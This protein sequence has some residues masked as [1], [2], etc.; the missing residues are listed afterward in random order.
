M[1]LCKYNQ[2]QNQAQF[3]QYRRFQA[4]KEERSSVNKLQNKTL[5]R[6]RRRG[7]TV[8]IFAA[9][10]VLFRLRTHSNSCNCKAQI[11]NFVLKLEFSPFHG[12]SG[13]KNH[14]VFSLLNRSRHGQTSLSLESVNRI[15]MTSPFLTRK[16]EL[17]PNVFLPLPQNEAT[18]N[19]RFECSLYNKITD[20]YVPQRK[21][22]AFLFSCSFRI[23][24]SFIAI[25]SR[26][27]SNQLVLSNRK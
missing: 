1:R 13:G 3:N 22:R 17:V 6:Q 19:N 8:E 27:V 26:N 20:T 14:V 15:E 18:R 12:I 9:S 25:V 5:H 4:S 23:Q 10:S 16:H 11:L 2:T 21:V 24:T 7:L